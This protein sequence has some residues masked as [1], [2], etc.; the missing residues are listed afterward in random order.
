MAQ[1][2]LISKIM[3]FIIFH[4]D[5]DDWLSPN[6]VANA[7]AFTCLIEESLRWFVSLN[8]PPNK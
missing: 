7:R 2:A 3:S 8:G 4:I 1:T 5:I 6:G